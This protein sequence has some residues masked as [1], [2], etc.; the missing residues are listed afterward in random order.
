MQSEKRLQCRSVCSVVER[1]DDSNHRSFHYAASSCVS[2]G[3]SMLNISISI[4]LE[5]HSRCQKAHDID[6]LRSSKF[7]V[8][9]PRKR[10]GSHQDRSLVAS[11]GARHGIWGKN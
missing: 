4:V 1:Q 10:T 9:Y 5:S 2:V 6:I 7:T 11:S 8:C 3:I